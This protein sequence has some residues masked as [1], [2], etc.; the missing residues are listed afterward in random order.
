MYNV[1]YERSDGKALSFSLAQGF[2]IKSIT[3]DTGYG[4]D[5]SASQGYQQV[6]ELV[7]ATSIGGQ[8]LTMNGFVLDK[9]TAS[10]EAL[11]SVFA[12]LT[13][14]RLF[15]EDKY[16][17]DVY[18]SSSPE[19]SQE[20]HSKFSLKLFAPFPFWRSVAENFSAFGLITP[21]F[22]F[23]VNYSEPHIFGER[24]RESLAN[25]FNGG[26]VPIEFSLEISSRGAVVNPR[27]SN[28][29]TEQ[30]TSFTGTINSGEKLVMR[31]VNGEL[32]VVISEGGAERNA[33]DMLDVESDFFSLAVGDN[34]VA[35]NADS[36]DESAFTTIKF[37]IA[38]AGVLANGV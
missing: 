37:S 4:V 16:Y 15:W 9:K 18:V 3:G 26:N 22:S 31:R 21:M 29:T 14:G 2:I 30:E 8:S 10:K 17:I 32:E 28:L 5:I 25:C 1:R 11:L 34:V 20:K 35:M 24:S 36:G 23:P 38:K 12:P 19:I 27:I 13:R 6:G 33:F 7:D